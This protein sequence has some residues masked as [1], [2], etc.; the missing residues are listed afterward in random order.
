MSHFK[1][2]DYPSLGS[3][4]AKKQEMGE[5]PP[6]SATDKK[7]VPLT[8]NQKKNHKRRKKQKEKELLK[9]AEKLHTKQQPQTEKDKDIFECIMCCKKGPAE[10]VIKFC[11]SHHI[12]FLFGRGLCGDCSCSTPEKEILYRYIG[13]DRL[14]SKDEKEKKLVEWS[15]KSSKSA[16]QAITSW[17]NMKPTMWPCDYPEDIKIADM[18]EERWESLA[19]YA[20]WTREERFKGEEVAW[21]SGRH[22]KIMVG[23]LNNLKEDGKWSVYR[24]SETDEEKKLGKFCSKELD[25]WK[26][27]PPISQRQ[28]L[29]L[30]R[31]RK[32]GCRPEVESPFE[33]SGCNRVRISMRSEKDN[34][35]KGRSGPNKSP[36]GGAF[37]KECYDSQNIHQRDTNMHLA[38]QYYS[39]REHRAFGSVYVTNWSGKPGR[40]FRTCSCYSCTCAGIPDNPTKTQTYTCE[41]CGFKGDGCSGYFDR[42]SSTG[43][44]PSTWE[45][46]DHWFC[47]KCWCREY[48]VPGKNMWDHKPDGSVWFKSS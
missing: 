42:S 15:R 3:Q 14:D 39:D 28:A 16:I 19:Y 8:K 26:L 27:L 31:E 12:R 22:G 7:E 13:C 9:K 32:G 4:S 37:C 45:D 6:K 25:E 33:C 35:D 1:T 47:K 44:L 2:E 24:F 48:W 20:V 17:V 40:T 43:G 23:K 18:F 34:W 38:R 46:E 21:Y 5:N 10:E 36:Y 11:D 29:I 30:M 41:D